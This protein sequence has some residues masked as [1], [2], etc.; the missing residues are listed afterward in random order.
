MTKANISI[1]P[2]NDAWIESQIE[3]KDYS[4]R[5][6]VLNDLIH[7]ARR[8]QEDIFT[9]RNALIKG[10]ESGLSTR[11]PNDIINSVIDARRK[12]GTL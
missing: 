4:N 10:E 1:T 3:S 6:D 11:T 7:Q 5:S 12:N 8:K 2:H 9:I